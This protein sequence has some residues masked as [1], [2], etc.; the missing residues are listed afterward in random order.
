MLLLIGLVLL[1]QCKYCIRKSIPSAL[2]LISFLNLFML[3][4]AACAPRFSLYKNCMWV[5]TVLQCSTARAQE[6]FGITQQSPHALIASLSDTA[7]LLGFCRSIRSVFV[8]C[9]QDSSRS[10]S[11]CGI[12][13]LKEEVSKMLNKL[14]GTWSTLPVTS[15]LDTQSMSHLWLLPIQIVMSS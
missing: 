10:S 13:I 12:V 2:F 6:G 14:W 4:V 9:G 15:Q 8:A 1:I 11:S 3:A 5:L 7:S